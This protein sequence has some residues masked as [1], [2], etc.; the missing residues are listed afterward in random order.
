VNRISYKPLAEIS[1]NLQ[2]MCKDDLAR[3]EVK[4]SKVKGH[5][6]GQGHSE[7]R[8]GQIST[9]GILKVVCSN[10]TFSDNLRQLSEAYQSTVH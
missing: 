2:L 1:P 10:V 9:L 5:S 3:F 4:R 7:T 8:Y 6:Q